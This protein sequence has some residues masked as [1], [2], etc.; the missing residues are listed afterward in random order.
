M[1]GSIR[2]I[3]NLYL[4]VEIDKDSQKVPFG[5]G[6]IYPIDYLRKVDEGYYDIVFKDGSI[7][8]SVKKD[9]LF[10][11][12]RATIIENDDMAPLHFDD[13][14]LEKSNTTKPTE[15]S[16]IEEII[17]NEKEEEF[18]LNWDTPEEKEEQKEEI[19]E[20]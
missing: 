20:S 16:E 14:E 6:E 15:K 1:A 17:K 18:S 12:M 9:G 4:N 5:Y 8:H 10:E 13:I 11:V 7:A 2:F 3:K 19:N